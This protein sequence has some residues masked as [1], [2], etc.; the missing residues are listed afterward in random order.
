MYQVGQAYQGKSKYDVSERPGRLTIKKTKLI[1]RKFKDEE[2]RLRDEP[3]EVCEDEGNIGLNTG[4]AELWDLAC[5]LGTPVKFDATNAKLGV[6]DST[7]AEAAAQTDLQGATTA[8]ASMDAA[9]PS[10]SAQTVSWR[11]TFGS[12]VAN[13]PWNEFVVENATGAAGE[14][15]IRKVS[16]QGTKIS[17]QTWELTLQVTLA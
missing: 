4:I 6:S 3:Y 5:G 9:Y 7:A 15:L 17:G 16:L 13:F 1:L 2:A 11:S 10:R 8:H 12:A 14:K